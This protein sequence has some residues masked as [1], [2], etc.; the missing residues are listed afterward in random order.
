MQKVALKNIKA[1]LEQIP[2]KELVQ[3]CIKLA[4]CKKE[5]KE[6]LDY[7]IFGITD[8][9]AFVDNV[10]EELDGYFKDVHSTNIFYAKKTIRKIVRNANKY[11][12]YSGIKTTEIELLVHICTKMKSTEVPWKKSTAMQNLY[13]AQVKKIKKA[14]EQLHEDIQF[15]YRKHLENL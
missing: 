15:D 2:H 12:R 6:L 7:L 4:K 13:N 14:F 1:E 8:E 5:N 11:I 3:I 10:K 9:A